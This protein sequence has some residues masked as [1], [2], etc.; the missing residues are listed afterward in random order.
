MNL[1]LSNEVGLCSYYYIIVSYDP[2]LAFTSI[3]GP[4]PL[5]SF[6]IYTS[7]DDP[8]PLLTSHYSL[9]FYAAYSDGEHHADAHDERRLR[10]EGDGSGGSDGRAET[11]DTGAAKGSCSIIR[12]YGVFTLTEGNTVKMA[13]VG[14]ALCAE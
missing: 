1:N 2:L 10:Q 7:I 8:L 4:L 3:C 6:S 14:V 9:V 13:S 11:P 5:F 12:S